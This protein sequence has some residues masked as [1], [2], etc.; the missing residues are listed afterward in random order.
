MPSLTSIRSIVSN[1]ITGSLAHLITV[2]IASYLES[3]SL[4]T[5]TS[6]QTCRNLGWSHSS[7]ITSW[8][9]YGNYNRALIA[10]RQIRLSRSTAGA[11]KYCDYLV[12]EVSYGSRQC[13]GIASSRVELMYRA[14][15]FSYVYLVQPSND[16]TLYALKKIRC[17][18]GQESVAQALKEVEAYSLFSP[19]PNI[20]HAIDHSV[21]SDKGGDAGQKTVYI[22][23]P[24]YRRG[25][26]QDAINANLVNRAH[27]PE[28]RL[29]VLF[30]GVCR[31]LKAMHHYKVKGAPGGEGARRKAKKVRQEA[32]EAD[33]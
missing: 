29:M 11:S 8:M 23:L 31:A 12:K 6:R 14:L 5:T 33:R 24:Y 10:F 25:N 1:A 32:A 2:L 26:L 20:I 3:S 4:P 7:H 16:P 9:V 18:F 22:L 30:L 15:G 27:F 21:E 17:P 13:A 28:R 19:H